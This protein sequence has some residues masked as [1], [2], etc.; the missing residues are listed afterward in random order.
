MK[1]TEKLKELRNANNLSQRQIA[2]LLKIDVSVYNRFE[3]GERI[4]K[5]DMVIRVADLYNVSH[6]E[7][8]KYWLAIQI[9]SLLNKE[10]LAPEVIEMVSEDIK[11]LK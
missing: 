1:F 6:E 2:A 10:E 9:Y 11:S 5:R 7:L 8:L 3:K 4:M